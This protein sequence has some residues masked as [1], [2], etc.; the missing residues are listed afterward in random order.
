MS[1]LVLVPRVS[2]K[3][4]AGAERGVYVFEVPTGVNKNAI[5]KAV[6][7][8]FKVAVMSI[9]TETRKGKLKRFKRNLGR[10]RD[11]KIAMVTL[12]KGQSIKLFEGSK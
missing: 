7:D 5:A 11:I 4:I 9:N 8:Q 1:N 3:A 6:A 12:K 10:Q 2:E